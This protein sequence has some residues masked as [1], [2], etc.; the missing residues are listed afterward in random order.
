MKFAIFVTS[1][2]AAERNKKRGKKKGGN[3]PMGPGGT[4]VTLEGEW[5]LARARVGI[6]LVRTFRPLIT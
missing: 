6:H 3:A 1:I 4:N 2:Q 5:E